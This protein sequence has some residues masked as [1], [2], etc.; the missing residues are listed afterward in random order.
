MP[1]RCY[2]NTAWNQSNT[3]MSQEKVGWIPCKAW[4]RLSMAV[5]Y[6]Q[7]N[8][9]ERRIWLLQW[10]QH[11]VPSR[12]NDTNP[13]SLTFEMATTGTLEVSIKSA[14]PL[15]WGE[16]NY[17][18]AQF[19]SFIDMWFCNVRTF[20]LLPLF[21]MVA[22]LVESETIGENLSFPPSPS[23]PLSLSRSHT[24]TFSHMF[25]F[26]KDASEDNLI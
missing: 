20:M 7:V 1:M 2:Y 10:V 17:A 3:R 26:P 24:R 4:T 11:I 23:P 21:D 25:G 19:Y 14:W 18:G 6:R 9:M 5:N 22:L 13:P 8:E 16:G 12:R 15:G